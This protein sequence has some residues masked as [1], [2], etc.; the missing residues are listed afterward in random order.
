MDTL[1]YYKEV[2]W[3]PKVPDD[4]IDDL[5]TIR[6]RKNM[7]DYTEYEHIYA[8]YLVSKDLQEFIQSQFSYPV[9]ARYQVIGAKLPVHCDIGVEEKYNYIIDTGGKEVFTRWWD[10]LENP[11]T[12][13]FESHTPAKIWHKMKVDVPHDITEIERPRISIQVKEK[14]EGYQG[15]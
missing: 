11:E 14:P 12:I 7:F 15:P 2:D 3:L 5:G 13:I 6:S 10:S 8:S 1:I 9:L 4:L